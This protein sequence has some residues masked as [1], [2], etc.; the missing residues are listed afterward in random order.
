MVACLKTRD[1]AVKDAVVVQASRL[2]GAGGMHKGDTDLRDA[3]RGFSGGTIRI[4]VVWEVFQTGGLSA[5][6]GPMDGNAAA[7]V[8]CPT[9]EDAEDAE[10]NSRHF[11]ASF[12][13]RSFHVANRPELTS[14]PPVN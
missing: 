2:R 5:T 10:S 14:R 12:A 6:V 8:W 4:L 3:Q 11:P 1:A 9:A 7:H 13:L